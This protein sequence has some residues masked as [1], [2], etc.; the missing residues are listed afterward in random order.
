[1][2]TN[3]VTTLTTNEMV[4]SDFYEEMRDRAI[5]WAEMN[6][7]RFERMGCARE[8]AV[9]RVLADVARHWGSEVEL[10]VEKALGIR[11]EVSSTAS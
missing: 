5:R 4:P 9:K 6:L 8:S 10:D 1:M 3:R 2:D 7:G 11:F